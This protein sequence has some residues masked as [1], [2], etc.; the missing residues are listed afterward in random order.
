MEIK[1]TPKSSIQFMSISMCRHSFEAK[2]FD[3]KTSALSRNVAA[4]E[5]D[6]IYLMVNVTVWIFHRQQHIAS[7]CIEST[8]TLYRLDI[9]SEDFA[10][11]WKFTKLDGKVY[12]YENTAHSL[13][14]RNADF[15]DTFCE[16][17]WKSSL[18]VGEKAK[19]KNIYKKKKYTKNIGLSVNRLFYSVLW[20]EPEDGFGILKYLIIDWLHFDQIFLLVW[21]CVKFIWCTK[22]VWTKWINWLT[23]STDRLWVFK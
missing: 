8:H 5:I 4:I 3:N 2:T 17:K 22:H 10:C 1:T 13:V 16:Y 21:L 19:L 23:V 14:V 7:L 20:L 12:I 18:M 9:I 15:A 6:I 11:M